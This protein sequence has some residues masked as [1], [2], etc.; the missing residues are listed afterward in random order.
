M[1]RKTR[2]GGHAS[3]EA[4]QAVES[5]VEAKGHEYH[6]HG[7]L[8]LTKTY[9]EITTYTDRQTGKRVTK[10]VGPAQAD[11]HATLTLHGGRSCWIETKSFTAK[12][13]T[14][15]SF[16]TTSLK[17]QD[18]YAKRARQFGQLLQEQKAGALAFYLALWKYK[19]MQDAW[20]LHPLE[21]ITHVTDPIKGIAVDGLPDPLTGIKFFRD[22]G[23]PV[24]EVNGMP[25]FHD[26]IQEYIYGYEPR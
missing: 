26:A 13:Y 23:M 8:R 4:G 17:F 14:T 10:M 11:Y 19:D 1:R 18:N 25:C 5:V 16:W 3:Q 21:M 20:V 22:R 15:Y 7:I 2:G 12:D 9:P 6:Q 24:V